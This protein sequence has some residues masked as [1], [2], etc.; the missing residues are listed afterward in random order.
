MDNIK[1]ILA[2]L[3]LTM[4]VGMPAVA[5]DEL[6]MVVGTYTDLSTSDGMYVYRFNQRTGKS[7]LVGDVQADNPSFLMMNHDANRV[8][9]VSEYDDGRQG[10]GAFILNK[11]EGTMTP[12]HHYM[13]ANDLGNDC[14]WRFQVNDGKEFLSNPVLAYQA[15]K[16]TGPRHL[17]FNSKG[18]VAY[19]IGELDGTV[20]V[21]GYNKGTLQELQRIQASK[22]RTLGSADI[23]LSPDGR[24]LYASHRL[25][26]EGISVFAV[27]KKSGLLTKIDFQPTAAH[28]RNFAI[29]P[30]G[31]FMLVA[32]RDSH[33]IQVFKL[34]KKTGMMVDTK[35]DIK[36]GKPV[37]VQ[38]A[39]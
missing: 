31:Q 3:S 21:L 36:V 35:L 33:V 26:D 39:N 34:N 37:C 13:L 6:T 15:P 8:Y 32:C 23:H 12:D 16:G 38:F 22:T 24:F 14:I 17:V 25:T 29:T 9:A 5:S 28:P 18:N 27:D 7:Q 1:T 19:L 11:K 2:G 30:N 10:L 4:A 20:T